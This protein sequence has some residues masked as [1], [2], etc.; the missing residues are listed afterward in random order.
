M[1]GR[2]AEECERPDRD[3]THARL[4]IVQGRAQHFDR[5]G[6]PQVPERDNRLSPD[7]RRRITRGEG[8][9]AERAS[10]LVLAQGHDQG[11]VRR[12]I[13]NT[14]SSPS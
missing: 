11:C 7:I 10:V 3:P 13:V 5:V 12:P 2:V 4:G 1:R 9:R 8:E 14:D 6:H